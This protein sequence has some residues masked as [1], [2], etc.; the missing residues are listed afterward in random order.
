[1]KTHSGHI[2]LVMLFFVGLFLHG[3]VLG[4]HVCLSHE[5]QNLYLRTMQL[6]QEFGR[7]FM[8]PLLL[9]D[10]AYGAGYAFPLFY[11]PLSAWG[12]ALLT[13][14][15]GDV[16]QGVH[17]AFFL[18][19]LASGYT[20]HWMGLKLTRWPA[21]AF[22]GAVL[23]LAF[24]YRFGVIFVRGA[25][26]E[27][28]G[29]IWFPLIIGSLAELART[30]RLPWLLPVSAAGLALTHTM[31][32]LFVA[33]PA[34]AF[35]LW[36]V[37]RSPRWAAPRLAL[38]G[39]L[40]FALSAWYLIPVQAYLPLVW[41]SESAMMGATPDGLHH[42]R[43]MPDQFFSSAPDRWRGGSEAMGN[44]LMSFELGL[45]F[46]LALLLIPIVAVQVTR[47]LRRGR[48]RS[49]LAAISLATMLVAVV[50]M[51]F[52][53]PFFAVLPDAFAIIQFP[54]RLIAMTNFFALVWAM[55][56]VRHLAAK[57]TS[58]LPWGIA[59]LAIVA[60]PG[61]QKAPAAGQLDLPMTHAS[62]TEFH[63]QNYNGNMGWTTQAEYFPR[64]Y[65]IDRVKE[66]HPGD[67]VVLEGAAATTWTKRSRGR[68]RLE[69]TGT[70]PVAVRVP[71]VSYPIWQARN[72]TTGER[73]KLTETE[74]LI[75]VHTALA[76]GSNKIEFQRRS[77]SLMRVSQ[78]ISL[79]T[80]LAMCGCW[81]W[82]RRQRYPRPPHQPH[83]RH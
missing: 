70:G 48:C 55:L 6:A 69:L 66:F 79:V 29:L 58:W 77:T 3:G 74:G 76:E 61:W 18:G 22:A 52:P 78:A 57:P 65:P 27:G 40:A 32:A 21:L 35:G 44:D 45:P 63:M 50:F 59:A 41:V 75:V 7:G 36:L 82:R 14:L 81:A 4:P 20:F 13:L 60:V 15:T 28:W 71:I 5:G 53:K 25:L 47:G 19:T 49:A 38:A 30:R 43:V 37:A 39:L 2:H 24:P 67:P 1:V 56:A 11:P 68:F 10:G 80:L 31:M 83:S 26:A 51:L 73:L 34:A 23:Y 42:H 8:P 46:L 9:A 62:F 33:L 17:W 16:I 72:T 54:W 64:G 12:A